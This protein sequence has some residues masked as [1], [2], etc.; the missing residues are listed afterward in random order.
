MIPTC[1]PRAAPTLGRSDALIGGGLCASGER[2]DAAVQA[3]IPC[4]SPASA[5]RTAPPVMSSYSASNAALSFASLLTARGDSTLTRRARICYC[6]PISRIS[7]FHTQ[8]IS[9]PSTLRPSLASPAPGGGSRNGVEQAGGLG[10]PDGVGVLH[11]APKHG[12]QHRLQ[13]R[14]AGWCVRV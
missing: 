6:H 3:P 9:P 5:C 10:G 2:G 14:H 12:P 13:P 4:T 11:S 1:Q 7:F 8:A